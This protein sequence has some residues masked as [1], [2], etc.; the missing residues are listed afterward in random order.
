MVTQEIA[1]DALVPKPGLCWLEAPEERSP[2]FLLAFARVSFAIQTAL[3]SRVPEAYFDDIRGFEDSK[4]AFPMLVYHASQPFRCRIRTDL[5]YDVLNPRTINSLLRTAK[6]GLPDL[7]ARVENRL[8]LAG[9]SEEAIKPY[10]S[11]KAPDMIESVQGLAKSRKNLY[12]L[13]RAEGVLMDALIELGGLGLAT[14]KQQSRKIASFQKKWAFQ[15]RR[16]YPGMDFLW[17]APILR[18]AASD[19]LMSFL[20]ESAARDSGPTAEPA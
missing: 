18:N 14:P 17:L 4:R 12:L 13:V 19:G 11:R 16:L 15:L 1:T 5:T 8:N 2:T 9:W 6:L 7:L 20:M 10:R 3:R